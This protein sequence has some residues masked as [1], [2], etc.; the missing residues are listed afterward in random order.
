MSASCDLVLYLSVNWGGLLH[1]YGIYEP[2]SHAV[3]D[4]IFILAP[5][6]HAHLYANCPITF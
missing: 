2:S 3:W 5:A 6:N 4:F 1:V